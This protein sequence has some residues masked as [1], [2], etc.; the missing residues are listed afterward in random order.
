MNLKTRWLEFKKDSWDSRP[1]QER[2]ILGSGSALL[3][4]LLV[5]FLL[6]QPAHS[7]VARLNKAL[8]TLRMQNAML[9]R[10]AAEVSLLRQRAQPAL[11][12]PAAMKTAVENSAASF[13]LRN[14]IEALDGIEPNGVRII[15]SSVSYA[16]WLKW[17][18]NLQQEQHIRVETLNVVALQSPGMVKISA[19]LVNGVSQ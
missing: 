4:P 13:Q 16:K 11:L 5:Y 6:W 15:F 19:T 3:M 2:R 10:Q 9:Q 18:R 7:A 12:N 17:M 8:P 1:A 14:S